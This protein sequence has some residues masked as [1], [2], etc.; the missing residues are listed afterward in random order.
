M[1]E[2]GPPRR[3]KPP[4][5]LERQSYRRRRVIDAARVLP[6][7][8]MLLWLVPL[9]W[10]EEGAAAVRSS[11][12]ILYLFGVWALLVLGAVVLSSRLAAQGRYGAEPGGEG[13]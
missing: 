5:F 12:A 10:A 6:F 8:G 2:A 1:S 9:L 3:G 11:S 7:I 13:G 4:V